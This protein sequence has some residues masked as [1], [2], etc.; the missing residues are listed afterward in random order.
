MQPEEGATQDVTAVQDAP[1]VEQ[2]TTQ[3]SSPVDETVIDSSEEI[4]TQ[5]EPVESDETNTSEETEAVE[6]EQR[7]TELSPKSQNRFQKLAN[8]KNRFEQESRQLRE[9]VSQLEQLQV[10]TEE[11]YLQGGYNPMEAK[12]NAMQAH[13][14]QRDA[15]E[16]VE[17]LNN[18]ID[19]DSIRIK[20]E[21]PQLDPTNKEEFNHELTKSLFS[22]YERDSGI[23]FTKDGIVMGTN[24][25]PYQYIKDK[26]DLI[27][28][29]SANARVRA[30]KDVEKM[31]S[32]ADAQGSRAP[33]VPQ[34]N[35]LEAMRERLSDV[36]F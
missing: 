2:T 32:A 12:V 31:V 16:K 35:S 15:I 28:I 14:Q 6:E 13:M 27:G 7:E 21:F 34:D 11:D 17:R 5:D 24:Q 26:M 1:V 19:L 30:Q 8:E 22:Q 18:A 23:Q 36:K 10:P 3:D 33:A 20:H 4:A 9:R 29:A 25:L